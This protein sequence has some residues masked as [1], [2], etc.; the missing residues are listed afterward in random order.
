MK[1][2]LARALL[3]LATAFAVAQTGPRSRP[4]D[5][6]ASE[7]RTEFSIG[8]APLSEV[9]A[10]RAF[11]TDLNRGYIVVEVGMFPEGGIPV[12]IKTDDFSLRIAGSKTVL[13]PAPPQTIAAALQK[14]PPTQ[15]DVTIYQTSGIGYETGGRD[16]YG[17]RYPGGLI[18]SEGVAVG[19]GESQPASTDAD[20]RVM[21]TELKDKQLPQGRA[22]KPVGGY[23]Y[24]PRPA[25]QKAKPPAA[26][27]LEYKDVI[28]KLR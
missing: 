21:E 10:R 7:R 25:K 9:Q 5:Y 17:N 14:N 1:R 4:A 23:L 20:R 13:R 26:Y 2:L 6:P 16:I 19:I 11:A 12:E 15:H 22:D 28:L 8:A 18:T 3:L 27:Q 24:F